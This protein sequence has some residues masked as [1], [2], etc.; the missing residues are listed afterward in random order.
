VRFDSVSVT[1]FVQLP[2][3]YLKK[4][5]LGLEL[6]LGLVISRGARV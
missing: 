2:Y 4:A 1:D 3:H 6:G 5:K